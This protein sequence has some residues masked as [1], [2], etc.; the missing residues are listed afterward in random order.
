MNKLKKIGKGILG[1][2]I[3][4]TGA[5]IGIGAGIIQVAAEDLIIELID[6]IF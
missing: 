5:A 2:A 4:V 1:G 3:V 6:N